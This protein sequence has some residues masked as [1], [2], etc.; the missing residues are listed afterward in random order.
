MRKCCCA[1]VPKLRTENLEEWTKEWKSLFQIYGNKSNYHLLAGNSLTKARK[2]QCALKNYLLAI[3]YD[4]NNH[5]AHYGAA[6]SLYMLGLF[7]EALKHA[8][9]SIEIF[10]QG[11]LVHRQKGILLRYLKR[12]EEAVNSYLIAVQLNRNNEIYYSSLGVG[13]LLLQRYN[14]ALEALEKSIQLNP[15]FESAYNA[16]GKVYLATKQFSKALNYFQVISHRL[17]AAYHM[18]IIYVHLKDYENALKYINQGLKMEEEINLGVKYFGYSPLYRIDNNY[19]KYC[20]ALLHYKM[21]D[22][23]KAFGCFIS[24]KE[25][26]D[27]DSGNVYYYS[28]LS[29]TKLQNNQIN[30]NNV[31]NNVNNVNNNNNNNN[32]NNCDNDNIIVNSK[33]MGCEE[34]IELNENKVLEILNNCIENSKFSKAYYRRGEYYLKLNQKE[35]A[36][37]D[38]LCA[39]ENRDKTYPIFHLSDKKLQLITQYVQQL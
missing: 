10:P 20:F 26:E 35:L 11:H 12:Y 39:I 8:N 14:E 3:E 28:A 21:G 18:G 30:N 24:L 17:S 4:T 22:Y 13:Y 15:K 31:K 29:L 32:N 34:N 6:N 37:N 7:E 19:G 38:F 27:P 36:K 25:L 1:G 9:R 16:I 2:F 33:E 23:K 5:K